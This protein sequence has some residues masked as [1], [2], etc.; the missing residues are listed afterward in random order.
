LYTNDST[1]LIPTYADLAYSLLHSLNL[2]DPEANWELSMPTALRTLTHFLEGCWG[3]AYGL[4]V[5][6][7]STVLVGPKAELPVD[8]QAAGAV[9][10]NVWLGRL[11]EA[12]NGRTLVKLLG[13]TETAKGDSSLPYFLTS[14]SSEPGKLYDRVSS[15]SL[16]ALLSLPGRTEFVQEVEAIRATAYRWEL[17][18]KLKALCQRFTPDSLVEQF[19]EL[20]MVARV[21]MLI[22]G[23]TSSFVDFAVDVVQS[24]RVLALLGLT[25]ASV[26]VSS[27]WWFLMKRSDTQFHS[28]KVVSSTARF[29]AM[30]QIFELIQNLEEPV[31]AELVAELA[32]D[33]LP[34]VEAAAKRGKN[35]INFCKDFIDEAILLFKDFV[36]VTTPE[37]P[38]VD[39]LVR[40]GDGSVPSIIFGWMQHFKTNPALSYHLEERNADSWRLMNIIVG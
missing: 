17:G 38:S 24:S 9:N 7:L 29:R 20:P 32:S 16:A 40:M 2:V 26:L 33:A 39:T 6:T 35:K 4:A 5:A 15:E 21:F 28:S 36:H 25:I 30:S 34:Q 3:K 13:A 11:K 27:A 19:S 23:L 8:M 22:R 31:N 18:D 14:W 12:L 1:R 37:D 10:L